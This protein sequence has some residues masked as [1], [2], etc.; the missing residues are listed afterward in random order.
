MK[1]E[2]K[3]CYNIHDIKENFCPGCSSKQGGFLQ[4]PKAKEYGGKLLHL[5]ETLVHTKSKNEYIIREL[6]TKGMIVTVSKG[7]LSLEKK[8]C[9]ISEKNIEEYTVKSGAPK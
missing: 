9:Y 6:Q 2:C 1:I 5:R 7:I 3:A 8:K 4:V